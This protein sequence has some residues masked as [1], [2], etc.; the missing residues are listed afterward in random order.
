VRS[1]INVWLNIFFIIIFALFMIVS[2]GRGEAG[3][4]L[5]VYFIDYFAHQFGNFNRF[6]SVAYDQNNNISSIFNILGYERISITDNANQLMDKY[7]FSIN[8][9]ATFVGDLIIGFDRVVVF[10]M[11]M[12]FAFTY[13]ILIRSHSSGLGTLILVFAFCDIFVWGLFYYNH[14]WSISNILFVIVIGLRSFFNPNSG[15]VIILKPNSDF[16]G[17]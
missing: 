16:R 13:G 15:G 4:D 7:G 10:L 12:I 2:F 5:S 1:R 9:F 11:A 8:V 6:Y 14:N 17:L 3:G